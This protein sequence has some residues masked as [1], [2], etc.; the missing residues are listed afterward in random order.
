MKT[1]EGWQLYRAI[2]AGINV[3]RKYQGVPIDLQPNLKVADETLV[4][5]V[6]RESG[7]AMQCALEASLENVAYS[8]E[9]VE[10]SQSDCRYVALVDPLDGTGAFVSGLC[11]STVIIG[12]YDRERKQLVACAIGEPATGRVWYTEGPTTRLYIKDVFPYPRCK[13]WVPKEQ[14]GKPTILLDVSH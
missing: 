10:T 4:T 1:I 5:F 14:K 11:S 7:H 8:I 12:I 3:V 9:D 6:D 13:V 2:Q